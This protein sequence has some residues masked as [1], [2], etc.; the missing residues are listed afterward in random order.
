MFKKNKRCEV[1]NYRPVSVLS[2]VSKI[3]EWSVYTQLEQYLVQ[4]KLFFEFQSGFRS[5]FST[6][7]CLTYLTD[8][9]KTQTSKGLYTDPPKKYV[10]FIFMSVYS[11]RMQLFYSIILNVM[12]QTKIHS[13][14]ISANNNAA[15]TSTQ[16]S[17]ITKSISRVSSI[18]LNRRSAPLSH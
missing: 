12:H 14:I 8:Y 4:K 5:N 18:L 9:I 17:K 13:I 3:S 6:G 1:D 10:R 15:S 7:T 2:V 11:K 16:I